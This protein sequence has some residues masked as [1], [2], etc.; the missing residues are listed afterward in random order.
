MATHRAC[1]VAAYPRRVDEQ[2]CPLG[3]SGG[4]PQESEGHLKPL[5]VS[6]R[7][8]AQELMDREVGYDER[9]TVEPFEP[10][11]AQR[12]LL[13]NASD[14]SGGFMDQLECNPWLAT[15]AWLSGPSTDQLP[16]AQPQ[17]CR[18]QE[19][20]ADHSATER[21]GQELSHPAF[22]ACGVARF[23]FQTLFG[24]LRVNGRVRLWTR[25]VQFFLAGQ[26]LR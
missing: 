6:D 18:H 8:G 2:Q 11:L 9:Q 19:P 7:E 4:S 10:L 13:A 5:R 22:E 3:V 25:A 23:R 15:L 1:A 26:S 17:V 24:L 20:E 21:V 14:T 12:P 16:G